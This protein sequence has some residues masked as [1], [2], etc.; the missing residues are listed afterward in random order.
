[1]TNSLASG[2][3]QL[4]HSS[5][6]PLRAGSDFGAGTFTAVTPLRHAPGNFDVVGAMFV[7]WL[8]EC[9]EIT[10]ATEATLVAHNGCT[11]DFRYLFVALVKSGLEL[12]KG[13]N[14]QLLD[15][16]VRVS[17]QPVGTGSRRSIL[18]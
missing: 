16:L 6:T 12:P 3:P 1:M 10:G 4:A 2:A 13:V 11:C 9:I 7:E 8:E 14:W 18:S 5:R 17:S 15:S